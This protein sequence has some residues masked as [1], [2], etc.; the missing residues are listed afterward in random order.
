MGANMSAFMGVNTMF[1]T[2]TPWGFFIPIF[3]VWSI[4]LALCSRAYFWCCHISSLNIPLA[5][6]LNRK[7]T[8]RTIETWDKASLKQLPGFLILLVGV[9][10]LCFK[11]LLSKSPQALWYS[12]HP[13]GAISAMWYPC[14]HSAQ[15]SRLIF[16]LWHFMWEGR[17]DIQY[18]THV[19][20]HQEAKCRHC[21]ICMHS[22][23][24]LTQDLSKGLCAL[25]EKTRKKPKALSSLHTIGFWRDHQWIDR[26]SYCL[27]IVCCFVFFI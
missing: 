21:A 8:G 1:N 22:C 17:S 11:S 16:Y 4:Q 18:M 10:E 9:Q 15:V 20:L 2:I 14:I 7:F 19:Q 6:T 23:G 3:L 13:D 25:Q 27:L 12:I 5:R 26:I 24:W